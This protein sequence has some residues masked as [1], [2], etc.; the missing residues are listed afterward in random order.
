MKHA[1]KELDSRS[2]D[3]ISYTTD[4]YNVIKIKCHNIKINDDI[5]HC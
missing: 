1:D 5:L 4:D 3:F 2:G